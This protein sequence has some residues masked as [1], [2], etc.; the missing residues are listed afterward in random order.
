MQMVINPSTAQREVAVRLADGTET[1]VFIQ[2]NSR[3]TLPE[4]AVVTQD[5]QDRNPKIKVVDR[6]AKEQ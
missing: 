5:F 4:G 3:A 1:S 6:N 2:P